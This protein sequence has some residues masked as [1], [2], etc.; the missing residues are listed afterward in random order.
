MFSYSSLF[1]F[2]YKF[3]KVNL[4]GILTRTPKQ[5]YHQLIDAHAKEGWKF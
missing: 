4:E 5:N 3:I 1:M 2:E